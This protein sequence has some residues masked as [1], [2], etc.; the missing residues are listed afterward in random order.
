MDQPG[1]LKN[2]AR[3]GAYKLKTLPPPEGVKGTTSQKVGEALRNSTR[4]SIV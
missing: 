3:E 2:I 1:R 4:S